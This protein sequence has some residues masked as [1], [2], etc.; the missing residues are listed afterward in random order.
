MAW[1]DGIFGPEMEPRQPPATATFQESYGDSLGAQIT[2]ETL[3]LQEGIYWAGGQPPRKF[4]G[5]LS[6]D[7]SQIVGT[8]GPISPPSQGQPALLFQREETATFTTPE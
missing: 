1:R 3:M 5:K 4:T 7:G 6:F 2:G 8:W